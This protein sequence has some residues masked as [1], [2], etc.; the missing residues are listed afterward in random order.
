M[1]VQMQNRRGYQIHQ[2]SLQWTRFYATYNE[3]N[4]D[5]AEMTGSCELK[6]VILLYYSLNVN[7][8]HNQEEL[9]CLKNDEYNFSIVTCLT[10][11][12][13]KTGKKMN[14]TREREIFKNNNN[15]GFIQSKRYNTKM[16]GA[17]WFDRSSNRYK[18][19]R[20]YQIKTRIINN[21][22]NLI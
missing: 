5:I 9:R 7:L 12:Q 1:T 6:T 8:N 16:V 22:I 4:Y 19:G 2:V 3:T 14:K 13:R 11:S 18:N 20:K 21:L 15:L 10:Q 17:S